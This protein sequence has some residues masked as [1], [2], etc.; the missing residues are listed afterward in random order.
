[1]QTEP[2]T[3]ENLTAN[4]DLF[5]SLV[6]A[7]KIESESANL[8]FKGVNTASQAVSKGIGQVVTKGTVIKESSL[9]SLP[10]NAQAMYTKYSAN[11]WKGNVSGQTPGT[12]A[13]AK[14]FNKNGTLPPVDSAG[15]PIT[16]K[17]FDVNNKLPNQTRDKE[18][19][20]VGSNGSVYYTN[21]HYIDFTKIKL[22]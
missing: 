22:K 1:M 9:N 14:Y 3:M 19:F 11:G 10:Q 15:N 8:I 7:Y 16:Y 2:F 12:A 13:G 18:R 20:V 6:P 4:A 5:M 17:E 21:D